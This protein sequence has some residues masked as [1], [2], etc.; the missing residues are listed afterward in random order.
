LAARANIPLTES[1][2]RTETEEKEFQELIFA[3]IGMNSDMEGI[4][5]QTMDTT[6]G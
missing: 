3:D 2:F 5:G 4:T 1:I 6:L